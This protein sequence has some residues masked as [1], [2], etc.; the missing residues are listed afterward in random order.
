MTWRVYAQAV[1]WTRRKADRKRRE[2]NAERR[3]VPAH[4]WRR[5]MREELG[6]FNATLAA[7][8]DGMFEPMEYL[9]PGIP[10]RDTAQTISPK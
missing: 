3:S 1:G 5:Q 10:A 2:T 8:Q 4:E 7:M 6:L 9:A